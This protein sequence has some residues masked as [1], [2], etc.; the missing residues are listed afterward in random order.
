M[1]WDLSGVL[2]PGEALVA[3]ATADFGQADIHYTA[4]VTISAPTSPHRIS[5]R[6]GGILQNV[7]Y[8]FAGADTRKLP[9]G[10]VAALSEHGEHQAGLGDLVESSESVEETDLEQGGQTTSSSAEHVPET[11]SSAE[12][13]HATP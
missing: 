12:H 13:T 2:R 4:T 9:P 10:E 1:G 11:N 8:I 6:E 7:V 3:T 5:Y